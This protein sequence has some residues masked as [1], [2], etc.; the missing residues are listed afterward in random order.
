MCIGFHQTKTVSVQVLD[1][2]AQACK[3]SYCCNYSLYSSIARI[4]NVC[5]LDFT[6]PRLYLSR[7]LNYVLE[8]AKQATV[9]APSQVR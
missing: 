1:L 3:A 4:L 5:A 2:C 7:Y 8:H 9:A 6:K